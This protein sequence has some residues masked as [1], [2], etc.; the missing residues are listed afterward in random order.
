MDDAGALVERDLVPRNDPVLDRAARTELVERARVAPADELLTET[1]L[2]EA[3]V[4]VAADGDPLAVLA[5]PVLLVGMDG[6][7]DVRRQCPRRRRPDEER[8]RGI[9]GD[10]TREVD[11][12]IGDVFVSLRDLV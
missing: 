1:A 5:P 4:R 3:L 9:T 6:G 11:R 10:R 2:D 7:G 8:T 12:R